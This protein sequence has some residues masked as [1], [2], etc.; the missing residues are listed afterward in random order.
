MSQRSFGSGGVTVW[1]V[2]FLEAQTDLIIIDYTLN[3]DRYIEGDLE[4]VVVLCAPVIEDDFVSMHDL[5][6][7]HVLQELTITWRK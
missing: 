4:E 1:D 7:R 6:Q 3:T 2:V 5:L